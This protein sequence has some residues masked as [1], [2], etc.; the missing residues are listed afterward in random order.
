MTEENLDEESL[1]NLQARTAKLPRE[2]P[3]PAA[4]WSA[5]RSEIDRTTRAGTEP[6]RLES[7]PAFWQHPA[8]L[9]AAALL[10]IAGSSAITAIALGRREMSATSRTAALPETA[11]ARPVSRGN[12][13]ATL[14]EFAAAENDYIGTT[15]R[16]SA[17]LESEETQFSPE[18]IAK[19]KASL[20][21]IDAAI[22]E[23]R[24]ALAADP[25]NKQ[26]IEMLSTS[27]D[28]K[29]DLLKRTTEMGRS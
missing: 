3:P 2:I 28:Q 16:L 15:N 11:G 9:A 10:L 4:A 25:A 22:L 19:L 1:R 21:I 27:Y 18:T 29:V 20:A 5:I 13:P 26:L 12:G 14:A 23:A 7:R 24:R 17:L 6:H 8:L